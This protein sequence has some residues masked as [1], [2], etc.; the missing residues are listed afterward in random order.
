MTK[1]AKIVLAVAI[2]VILLGVGYGLATFKTDTPQTTN[3]TEIADTTETETTDTAE[4]EDTTEPPLDDYTYIDGVPGKNNTGD[5]LLETCVK[6]G[7]E[8]LT[9]VTPTFWYVDFADDGSGYMIA[10]K[11]EENGHECDI[12]SQLDWNYNVVNTAGAIDGEIMTMN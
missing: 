2:S 5:E 1:T 11:Y 9:N 6:K 12:I 8:S 10:V 3:T 4:V 7:I